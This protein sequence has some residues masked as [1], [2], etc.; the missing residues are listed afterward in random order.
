MEQEVIHSAQTT[1]LK[2]S[3]REEIKKNKQVFLEN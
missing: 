2:I 1:Q 3:S